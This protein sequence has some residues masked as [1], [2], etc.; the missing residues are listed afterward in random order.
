MAAAS[1][2][3]DHTVVAF[4]GDRK[5][6]EGVVTLA[7]AGLD[8]TTPMTLSEDGSGATFITL[9]PRGNDVV[10]M[11]IDSRRA[12]TPLHAR[13]ISLV[14]DQMRFGEDAVL[15]VGEGSDSRVAGAVA[16]SPSGLGFALMPTFKTPT[17]FGLA[18]IRID[19]KPQVEAPVT[20][21]DYPNGLDHGPVAATVGI[22]PVRVARVRPAS[23]EVGSR[24]VLDLG[25]LDP[26]GVFKPLCT[27]AEGSRF[28]DLGILVDR[29]GAF[30]L[31]YTDGQGTWVGRYS[32]QKQK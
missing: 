23:K 25:E 31:N 9:A 28:G 13:T 17:T 22:V 6:S 21:S 11:Y 30:W 3:G 29:T 10:A 1:I 26:S 4:L 15:F 32:A 2:G 20:W 7:F 24:H 12:M 27:A 8:E 16:F 19:E 5:T 18:A 14:G